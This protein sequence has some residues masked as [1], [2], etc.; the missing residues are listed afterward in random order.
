MKI[1]SEAV[2]DFC[3]YGRDLFEG[4]PDLFGKAV[5]NLGICL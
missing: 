1:E 3:T 5:G 2:L 4:C